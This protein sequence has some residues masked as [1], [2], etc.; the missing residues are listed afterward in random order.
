MM[1][2]SVAKPLLS[3]IDFSEVSLEDFE[4]YEKLGSG[5]Y[6]QVYRTKFKLNEEIYALKKLDKEFITKVSAFCSPEFLKTKKFFI[7]LES[8][9]EEFTKR[10]RHSHEYRS[11]EHNQAV[12]CT[13]GK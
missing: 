9:D 1:T 7:Y 13:K 3:Q 4:F 6:G 5:S 11:P 10:K 8:K 12:P 2:P